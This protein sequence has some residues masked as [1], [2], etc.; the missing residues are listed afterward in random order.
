MKIGE[1][2]ERTGV[3]PRML[4]YYEQQGL[5]GSERRSN[6]YRD[7]PDDAVAR[8]AEI[9]G[10]V[11]AGVPTR[12]IGYLLRMCDDPVDDADC[13]REFAESLRAELAQIEQRLACLGRSRDTLRTVLGGVEARVDA[14]PD[15][16]GPR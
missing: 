11:T 5:L 6:G 8:V 13:T 15:P 9:R 4:R 16:A 14:T 1:L 2:A 7:Y 3:A 10:L 12:M